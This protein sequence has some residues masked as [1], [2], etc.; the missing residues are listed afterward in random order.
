MTERG[1]EDSVM[2]FCIVGAGISGMTTALRLLRTAEWLGKKLEVLV[3]DANEGAGGTWAEEN[4]YPG[5]ITNNSWSQMLLDDDGEAKRLF[6]TEP[7]FRAGPGG[8]RASSAGMAAVMRSVFRQVEAAGAKFEFCTRVVRVEQ[9]SGG[10]WD[11]ITLADNVGAAAGVAS[12]DPLPAYFSAASLPSSPSPQTRHFTHLIIATGSFSTPSLPPCALPHV[13]S[14]IAPVSPREPFAVHTS[15][16]S[17]RSAQKALAG[18]EGKRRVVIVGASK[19][20]LDAAEQLARKG[21]DVKLVFR[22]APWLAPPAL[23][24]PKTGQPADAAVMVSQRF[25]LSYLPFFRDPLTSRLSTGSLL[26]SLFRRFLYSTLLGSYLHRFL[27]R[28]T[29]ALYA[30]FGRWDSTLPFLRPARP[31][32]WSEAGTVPA[33]VGLHDLLEEGKIEVSK[34]VVSGMGRLEGDGGEKSGGPFEVEVTFSDQSSTLPPTST[35]E[36]DVVIFGTGWRTGSYPFFTQ[37]QQEEL[38][39]PLEWDEGAGEEK[40]AREREFEE[41]DAESE[42]ELRRENRSLAQAPWAGTGSAASWFGGEQRKKAPYRLYR[43][44][45]PLAHLKRRDI[46]FV[47]IPTCKANHLLFL[48]QAH[49]LADYFLSPSFP[50][51]PS[52]PTLDIAKKEVSLFATWSLL[53]FGP[54]YGR[55]AHWLGAGWVEVAARLCNDMHIKG[56]GAGLFGAITTQNYA[57]LE[58]AR[59]KR[60]ERLG[61]VRN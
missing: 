61:V 46:A 16:L 25:K 8:F 41:M 1:S 17:R 2:R 12:T 53:L 13:A 40:P 51:T 39:L 18:K 32:L 30:A 54:A 43:N 6:Q 27:L 49:W 20:S 38:G 52:T 36:A 21:H 28:R 11:V 45:I 31:L 14:S 55:L 29:E 4:A 57:H 44:M 5:L 42:G 7:S 19:S 26:T 37:Q 3:V 58:E 24:D 48:V 15:A 60:D 10:G 9:P 59:R 33:P 56:D 35:L 23:K 50:S 22:S 47:G 34:G